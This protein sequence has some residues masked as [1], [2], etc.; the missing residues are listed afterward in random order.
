MNHRQRRKVV[1]GSPISTGIILLSA[2]PLTVVHSFSTRA[3]DAYPSTIR[4]V[5]P[6][7]LT[8]GGDKHAVVDLLHP[9]IS[10]LDPLAHTRRKYEGF[11]YQL[12]LLSERA[13]MM[14]KR[15]GGMGSTSHLSAAT[16]TAEIPY[17]Y[18]YEALV[19]AIFGATGID[20]SYDLQHVASA[21]SDDWGGTMKSVVSTAFLIT[22]STVGP[23]MMCLPKFAAGP[24]M[25]LSAALF[26]GEFIKVS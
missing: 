12:P 6:L 4:L 9:E 21:D 8:W 18:N 20:P 1:G 22:G 11:T 13:I 15:G 7:P 26:M 10:N 14:K 3:R 19:P 24:G 25:G 23:S 5:D 2:V 17:Y 16:L